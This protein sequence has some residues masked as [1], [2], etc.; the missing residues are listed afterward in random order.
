MPPNRLIAILKQKTASGK[1][2]IIRFFTHLPRL[3]NPQVLAGFQNGEGTFRIIRS[4]EYLKKRKLLENNSCQMFIAAPIDADNPSKRG[5]R[6]TFD[7]ATQGKRK[8]GIG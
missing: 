1:L 3:N 5:K 4:D 7:G 6:I 8:V 2:E